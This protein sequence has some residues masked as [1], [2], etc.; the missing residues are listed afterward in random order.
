MT[1]F[2]IAAIVFIA[3]AVAL[4]LGAIFGRR[5]LEGSSC[6]NTKEIMGEEHSECCGM[7]ATCEKLRD[8]SE[9]EA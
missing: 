3:F 8:G 6:R 2:L 1:T 5:M 9:P 4:S 7:H